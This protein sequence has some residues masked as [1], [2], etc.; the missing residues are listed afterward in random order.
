MLFFFLSLC[1]I[2]RAIWGQPPLKTVV[3]EREARGGEC[4]NYKREREREKGEQRTVHSEKERRRRKRRERGKGG[5]ERKAGPTTIDWQKEAANEDQKTGMN[6]KWCSYNMREWERSTVPFFVVP[7]SHFLPFLRNF[8]LKRG[9]GK[10]ERKEDLW[11]DH[12]HLF[13]PIHTRDW[14]G[15]LRDALRTERG[16]RSETQRRKEIFL[17]HTH[18]AR[19]SHYLPLLHHHH[20]V[21]RRE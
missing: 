21:A 17:T 10:K 13:H 3:V 19:N 16:G 7:P 1:Y 9:G 15:K 11:E 5:G 8:P 18:T 12:H 6:N 4:F 14:R 20:D 2:K